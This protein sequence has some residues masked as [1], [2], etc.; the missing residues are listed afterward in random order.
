MN[1]FISFAMGMLNTVKRSGVNPIQLLNIV[2]GKGDPAVLMSLMANMFGN[3]PNFQR[4]QQM[5]NGKSPEEMQKIVQNICNEAGVDFN[6]I[7]SIGSKFG[8][9]L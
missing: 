8:L 7:K 2:Q 6:S 1:N 5:C 4:A 3:D 9:K